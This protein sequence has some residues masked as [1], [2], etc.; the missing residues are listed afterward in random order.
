MAVAK[1][2]EIQRIITDAVEELKR[3]RKVN[4]KEFR[5]VPPVLWF[6][7]IGSPKPK[8]LVISANPSRPD[9]PVGNPRIPSATGWNLEKVD[10]DRLENDYNRYFFNNPATK[11]FGAN[12]ADKSKKE[13]RQGRIEDF[14]NGM[15]ASFYGDFAY[16]AIHIDILP[17]STETSFTQIDSEIMA[18]DGVPQWINTHVQELIR[19]IEPKLI[20]INGTSNFNYFN[21]CVN[22]GAQ[23]YRA[24]QCDK[25]SIWHANPQ[26]DMPPII[27]I[28]MN[29]GSYCFNRRE[30]LVNLGKEVKK[31]LKFK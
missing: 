8:V 16:Q 13:D 14:L 10:I 25:T 20:I 19:L 12:P 1:K 29:M 3:L 31:Q 17:F 11:W 15:D 21:L 18:I 7:D 24:I 26:P 2:T 30:E 22:V 28:S 9:Q 27:G 5:D 6:G 23:P 4:E